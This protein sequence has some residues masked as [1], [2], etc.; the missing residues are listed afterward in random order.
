MFGYVVVNKDELRMRE[1]NRYRAYYCGLCRALKK[2]GGQKA[3][4]ALS[5][6]MTFMTIVLDSLYDEIRQEGT[7]RCM[8]HPCREHSYIQS[9]VSDYAADMNLLLCYENFADDWKDD[10]SIAAYFAA[11]VLKKQKKR[12]EKKYPRQAE[13]VREY[14]ERLK[15][16]EEINAAEMDLASGETGTLLAEIF[17][18][19][20]DEWSGELRELGFYLG[21]FIYL[22]DAYEDM[23]KD[24]K[25]GTYNPFLAHFGIQSSVSI[26]EYAKELLLMMAARAS[27][28]FERLPIVDNAELLRNI[29][30][31]GIWS[32]WE[33]IRKKRMEKENKR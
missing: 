3:R 23:E 32:K 4:L 19:K 10:K 30:Y 27:E 9:A 20:E 33:E 6:D 24:K 14:L 15:K 17:D 13:A 25:Q 2:S 28:A 29:L 26:E 1:W 12:V 16:I 22:M 11:A 31:A 8:A 21:K 18:W 7:E 5:F